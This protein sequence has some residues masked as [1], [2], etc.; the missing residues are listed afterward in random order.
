MKSLLV[1][2][3]FLLAFDHAPND[4]LPASIKVYENL[5]SKV[6][7]QVMTVRRAQGLSHTQCVFE[8]KGQVYIYDSTWGSRKVTTKSRNAVDIARAMDPFATSAYYK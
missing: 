8:F 2:C 6:W 3:L 7:K 4:C 1:I 5:P